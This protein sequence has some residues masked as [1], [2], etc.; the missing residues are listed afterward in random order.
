M[1]HIDPQP[2]PSHFYHK[3]QKKGENFLAKNPQAC[4]KTLKP[5]W[6]SIIPDLHE[7]Y[8]GICAFT[9]HYIPLDVG[10]STVEH[11][12]PKELYPQHAYYWDNFRLVCG[13]L[14]GRKGIH[15]DI[16]D[17]F[18]LPDGWFTLHFPSLQLVPGKTIASKHAEKVRTTIA[19]LQLN[20]Q[21]CIRARQDKLKPYVLG[22]YTFDHLHDMAPFL[23]RELKRQELDDIQHPI[24]DT[25]K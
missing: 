20:N 23:A 16:L 24:W 2:E 25:Y 7:A 18:T 22:K 4:G 13:T 8:S 12:K 6:R 19:R 14:N 9:C 1:M 11:F 3:V 10:W 17:P 21:K 15:E 5:Y